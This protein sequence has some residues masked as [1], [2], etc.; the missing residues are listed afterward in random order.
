MTPER[1]PGAEDP[2]A[3]DRRATGADAVSNAADAGELTWGA[4]DTAGDVADSGACDWSCDG[5]DGPD[6]GCDLLLFLRLSTLLL[7]VAAIVPATG[8]DRLVCALIRGY[9]RWLTRFTPR[10]PGSPSCSA[11][12]LAAVREHGARRGLAAAAHR[13]AA[14]APPVPQCP[15][16][17]PGDQRRLAQRRA[18]QPR[19]LPS[20]TQSH[21]A[22]SDPAQSD[23]AQSD[24]A[25]S[26]P[27]PQ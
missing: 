24:P 3:E 22:Q 15:A 6:C 5:C 20:R 4:A 8:A 2:D 7:A 16:G 1:P 13:I 17:H 25:Q 12:A 21:P 23:P 19:A 10:C 9:R 18:A 27:N 14:C 26:L 11:Y